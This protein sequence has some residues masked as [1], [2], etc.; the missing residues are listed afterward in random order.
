MEII[1]LI[2]II[3]GIIVFISLRIHPPID[4]PTQRPDIY[5]NDSPLKNL[6]S[7]IRSKQAWIAAVYGMLMYAPITIIGIAWGVP[8][9]QKAYNISEMLAASV[10]STMFLGAAVGSPLAAFI[11]DIIMKNRRVPMFLGSFV[12]AMVWATVLLV[13]NI[14]LT[15]MYALFFCGG[16]AY[17]FKTLTFACICEIMPRSFSGTSIAF[18]NMIVMSTGI[19]FHP[20]IGN[21]IDY[22]WNG[23]MLNGSPLYSIDDYRFALL[24]IPCCVMLSGILLLFMRESHP[25]A[26][27]VKEFGSIP[28]TELL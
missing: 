17:T 11:S 18:V 16:I 8:F 28:D 14:P 26:S 7:I 10:V 5:K 20:A 13:P 2:G 15:A 23:T 4:N 22:S 12:A 25:E 19:I 21:L 27:I 3:V 1:A 6:L 9:I 24:I